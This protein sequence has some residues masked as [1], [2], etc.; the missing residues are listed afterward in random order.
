MLSTPRKNNTEH[1]LALFFVR[2]CI[3]I[4][5]DTQ[6][7]HP[8][9]LSEII[10]QAGPKSSTRGSQ[11]VFKSRL[12]HLSR[13]FKRL[14]HATLH[15]LVSVSKRFWEHG[16][17]KHASLFIALYI[18]T[19]VHLYIPTY[20][21]HTGWKQPRYSTIIP[22]YYYIT[23]GMSKQWASEQTTN[24]CLEQ[25][26]LRVHILAEKLLILVVDVVIHVIGCWIQ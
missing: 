17:N 5:V 21:V 22:R 4:A 19:S 25:P 8:F 12:L 1:C 23:D 26:R 16:R 6:P 15:T 14:R 7:P 11:F 10:S 9:T 24:N 13:L 2:R 3:Q 18:C 20:I